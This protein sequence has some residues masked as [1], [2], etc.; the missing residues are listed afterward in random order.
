MIISHQTPQSVKGKAK[1]APIC[2]TDNSG[3][4]DNDELR[5]DEREAA[6]ASPPKGKKQVTSKVRECFYAIQQSD[7]HN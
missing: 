1:A 2:L 7:C 5:G 4:S 3:L 6:I